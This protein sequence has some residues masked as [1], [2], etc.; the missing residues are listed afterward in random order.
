[1]E[2]G[3]SKALTLARFAAMLVLA[4]AGMTTFFVLL[5]A[6]SRARVSDMHRS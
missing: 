2:T 1:M 5:A 3:T 6:T 4:I